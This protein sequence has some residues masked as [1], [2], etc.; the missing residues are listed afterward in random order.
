MNLNQKTPRRVFFKKSL[1]DTLA[2]SAGMSLVATMLPSFT[3]EAMEVAFMDAP[4]A[5]TDKEFR[6]KVF[7]PATL[8]LQTSQMAVS[9]CTQKNAKEFAGFELE[10]A[11]SVTA[12][13]KDLA[14]PMP[15]MDDK[16]KGTL[17]KLKMAKKG[18][19]FDKAYI[20]AQYENHVFLRDLAANYLT[21]AAG[22]TDPAESQ[23]RH[24]ATLAHATFSEHVMITKRILG[25]LGA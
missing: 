6:M 14:T 24:L 3:A 11:K 12:V 8:S 2:I 25:E 9:K 7:G 23:G 13:L 4:T 19:E 20:E 15:A 18:A 22:K 10:E 16:A 5:A 21:H 1:R 17:E